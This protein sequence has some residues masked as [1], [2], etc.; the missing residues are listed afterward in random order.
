MGGSRPRPARRVPH[1][2]SWDS[3]LALI[4]SAWSAILLASLSSSSFSSSRMRPRSSRFSDSMQA[5]SFS[6]S[7]IRSA[8]MLF[9]LARSRFWRSSFFRT[10][11]R[12][13]V[14][15][16]RGKMQEREFLRCNLRV[17]RLSVGTGGSFNLAIAHNAEAVSNR[18]GYFGCGVC[19]RGAGL[20][21]VKSKG[22]FKCR[23]A[24]GISG[25]IIIYFYRF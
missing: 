4:A 23:S 2:V 6:S 16:R 21:W 3:S 25:C 18:L 22:V 9:D 7:R 5:Q 19:R 12:D 8:R 17:S 14:S 11:S 10:I 13:M 24:N 1:S 20:S 15:R